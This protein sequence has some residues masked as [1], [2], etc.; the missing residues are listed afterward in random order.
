MYDVCV[1]YFIRIYSIRLFPIISLL[2]VSSFFFFWSRKGLGLCQVLFFCIFHD[3]NMLFLG[4]PLNMVNY[5]D[6]FSNVKQT[7]FMGSTQFNHDMLS[8]LC[9]TWFSWVIFYLECFHVSL[10][11]NLAHNP[12]SV[13]I[14]LRKQDYTS[15]V[16]VGEHFIFFYPM[17]V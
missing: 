7:S 8:F 4:Y 15:Y 16:W 5:N 13:L 6:F 3:Y 1:L 17:E 11:E 9:I 2:K 10:W 12:L 14:R